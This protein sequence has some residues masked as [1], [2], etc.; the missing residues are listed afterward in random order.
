[1]PT[2]TASETKVTEVILYTSGSTPVFKASRIGLERV[3]TP[4]TTSTEPEI[5][6]AAPSASIVHTSTRTLP[7]SVLFDLMSIFA[8]KVA[9]SET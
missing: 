7:S 9:D 8:V 5:T 3:K 4:A 1:L 6:Y 2:V